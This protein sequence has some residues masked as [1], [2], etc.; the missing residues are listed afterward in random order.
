[1]KKLFL[2]VLLLAPM[3]ALSQEAPVE[4]AAPEAATEAAK[5]APVN[6]DI[7]AFDTNGDGKIDS[8]EAAALLTAD[9]S[10]TD[11]TSDVGALVEAAKSIKG[12]SGTELAI[13]IALLLAVIFKLLLSLIKVASKNTD[14]FKSPRGKAAL[15][16]TTLGLGALAAIGAGIA[17]SVGAGIGWV[18]VVIIGL[19]GPGAMVVHEISSLLPGVGKHAS[20]PGSDVPTPPANG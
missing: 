14:W 5:P 20:V 18:E 15:K 16:Y 17:A 2:I 13:A 9:P 19:S 3:P 11:V 7:S 4:P 12:K 6:V 10:V 1:M 8:T